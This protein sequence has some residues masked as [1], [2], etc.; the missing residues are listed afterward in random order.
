[1]AARYTPW[2][3]SIPSQSSSSGSRVNSVICRSC[4]MSRCRTSTSITRRWAP[5]SCSNP[6]HGLLARI[7]RQR[8]GE[9]E[10]AA[11]GAL[12]EAIGQ[13]DVYAEIPPLMAK[14]LADGLSLEGGG[15]ALSIG[16]A[17]LFMRS[18]TGN[19]MDVHLHTS[20]NL[21]RWLLRLDGLSIK[22]KLLLL[23]TWHTGP[24][25]RSTANRM[26][27]WPQPD[28]AAVAKLPH[29]WQD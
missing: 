14:A 7:L 26:E 15:E 8:S 12:G 20:A 13:V 28:A 17:G 4:S 16:A 24:E 27:P 23:M 9:D 10:T 11:I 5:T 1:M 19:P 18:L 6:S 2:P 21:R 29:R 25:V 22:T 3:A